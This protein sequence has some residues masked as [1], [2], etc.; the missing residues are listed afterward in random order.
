MPEYRFERPAGNQTLTGDGGLSR[1]LPAV[2]TSVAVSRGRLL[3]VL[4]I[5]FGIAAIVGNSIGAGIMRTPSEVARQLPTTTGYLL[6]WV[7]GGVYAAL[8]VASLAE[9]GV[10]MPR[11]GGQYV[12]AKT[13]FGPFAGF[14]VGWSDWVSSCASAAAVSMVVAEYTGAF[15]PNGDRITPIL[16]LG[17]VLVLTAVL[18]RGIKSSGLIVQ[19]LTLVKAIVLVGLPLVAFAMNVR[20]PVPVEPT[21]VAGAL[22]FGG[23]VMA[24]QAVIYSYDGWTGVLYFS[25]EV[26]DPA[27]DI[28]R[29]MFGGVASVFVIYMLIVV[30][31]LYVLGIRGVAADTF[32]AGQVASAIFGDTGGTVIRLIVILLGLS[33]LP[34]IIL[35]SSRVPYAMAGDGLFPRRA[36]V[37]NRGGTPTATLAASSLLAI[38]FIVT[39]TFSQVIAIAAF[40]FVLQ[41]VMS[42][43]ALFVLRRREPDRPRPYRAIGYPVTTAISWLGGMA[44]LI[45]VVVQDRRNS[46]IAIAILVACYPVYR[47]LRLPRDG[48]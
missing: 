37:V 48:G 27:R 18:W 21:A 7:L 40:F 16:A 5:W 1:I 28:P 36:T 41:Y 47:L 31:F 30:C 17:V 9:L 25:G 13:V 42:F 20:A 46:A 3:Q 34:P 32:P 15:V 4:G 14:V 22:T 38:A 43:S 24:M 19:A 2:T 23:F 39:G 45:G 29:S 26:K 8:G 35:M 33:A 6:A 10:L 12:F 44:F 11:S